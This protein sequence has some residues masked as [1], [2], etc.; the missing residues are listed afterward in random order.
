MHK[1]LKVCIIGNGFHSKRIQKILRSKKIKFFIFKP[2]SKKNYKSENLNFLDKFNVFFIISPN[3]THY[4]YIKLLHKKGYIFC[5]KPPTNNLN[6]LEKLK[7]IKSNKIYYNFN[8]RFSKIAEILKSK[9]QFLLQ[10]QLVLIQV[11]EFE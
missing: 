8:F 10:F 7:K 3:K 4:H 11:Q 1:H 2:K 6:E 9:K 5:E